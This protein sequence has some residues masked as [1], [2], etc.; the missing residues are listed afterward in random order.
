L[1][2]TTDVRVVLSIPLVRR[3]G[4]SHNPRGK[5]VGVMSLDAISEAG[6]A[7]LADLQKRGELLKFLA[8]HGGLLAFLD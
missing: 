8:D 7:W 6:T 4:G 1:D 3:L 2:R 5:V